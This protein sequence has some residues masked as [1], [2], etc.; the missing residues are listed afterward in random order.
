MLIGR[1]LGYTL[2]RHLDTNG[3]PR[4][5]LTRQCMYVY[6][7][8]VCDVCVCVRVC[9]CVR[10]LLVTICDKLNGP[11]LS[12]NGAVEPIRHKWLA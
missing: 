6:M 10:V 9:A 2:L 4:L 12:P 11:S 8:D 5:L 3:S 7:C 1:A